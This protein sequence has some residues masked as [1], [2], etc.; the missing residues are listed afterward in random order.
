MTPFSALDATFALL[1]R[2]L[3]AQPFTIPAGSM[4]PAVQV[5][6]YVVASKFSYGYSNFSL[7]LGQH[8]PTFAYARRSPKRGDIVIFKLPSDPSTDYI[9]RVIGLSGDTVQVKGG[10]TYLNG[11]ALK[12]VAIGSYDGSD[13]YYHGKP[14]FREFM[15]DG[16]RYDIME[17]EDGSAGDDTMVFNV[18]P[19]HYFMMGDNR[20]NSNDSRFGVGF[21]PAANIYAKPVIAISWPNGEFTMRPVK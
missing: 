20:D 1:F 5:G 7:P 21:V 19:G 9:K 10:I 13:P 3:V 11:I 14:L 2:T 15:P 16:T 18:P 12:R 6:D 4:L 17:V 8:L